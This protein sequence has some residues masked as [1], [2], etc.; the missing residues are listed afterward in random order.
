MTREEITTT[1]E[2][3]I[4]NKEEWI[5]ISANFGCGV[6]TLHIY[7]RHDLKLA[8]CKDILPMTI[9]SDL[10]KFGYMCNGSAYCD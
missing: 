5:T 1:I 7:L 6:E 9:T 2:V 4:N 8:F 10:Y 3:A